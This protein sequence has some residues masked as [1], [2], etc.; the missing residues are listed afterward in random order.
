MSRHKTTEAIDL[1]FL[2]TGKQMIRKSKKITDLF[3]G[4]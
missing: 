4:L 2:A 1:E 3:S